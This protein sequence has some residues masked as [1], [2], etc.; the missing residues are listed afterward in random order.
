MWL[1]ICISALV[2]SQSNLL[3]TYW[4]KVYLADHHPHGSS[5]CGTRRWWQPQMWSGC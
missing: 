4:C 2:R 3:D 5:R 1:L